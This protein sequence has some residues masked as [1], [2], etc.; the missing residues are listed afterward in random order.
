MGTD[1]KSVGYAYAGSN[2]AR[3]NLLFL[4][5]GRVAEWLIAPV[6]KTDLA[7]TNGGSNPSLSELVGLV[8][9]KNNLK[10]RLKYL[11]E[12]FLL[13]KQITL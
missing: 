10:K 1:C 4:I 3:P 11:S 8:L 5:F 12:F 2:P 6:L 9:N 13:S 7:K